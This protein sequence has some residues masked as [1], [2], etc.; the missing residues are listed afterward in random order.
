VH[1]NKTENALAGS[2]DNS[3]NSANID[4]NSAISYANA[5]TKISCVQKYDILFISPNLF[6]KTYKKIVHKI[7][8]ALK[9]HKK[10]ALILCSL[11][12]FCIRFST[13]ERYAFVWVWWKQSELMRW[14]GA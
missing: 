7:Y 11:N 1:A 10:A 9:W 5:K 3:R 14:N 2:M 13:F 4:T 12:I 6:Q 8:S